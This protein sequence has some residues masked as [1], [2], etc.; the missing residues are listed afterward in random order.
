MMTDSEV[1]RLAG[2]HPD[3]FLFADIFFGKDYRLNDLPRNA[4][5]E[6]LYTGES[7]FEGMAYVS[8]LADYL[9]EQEIAPNNRQYDLCRI[10]SRMPVHEA[11]RFLGNIAALHQHFLVNVDVK[12]AA[13]ELLE[14]PTI[15]TEQHLDAI[16]KRAF[17]IRDD[18]DDWETPTDEKV[19]RGVMATDDDEGYSMDRIL[20]YLEEEAERKTHCDYADLDFCDIPWRIPLS[21]ILRRVEDKKRS[22]K[23][24]ISFFEAYADYA[25]N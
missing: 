18:Y 3:Q 8:W 5:G 25:G 11:P 24:L 10:I 14:D 13:D 4:S 22:V 23:L 1:D 21:V 17:E 9:H 19:V 2:C 16:Q 20:Q 15:F 7:E 6:P 12:F